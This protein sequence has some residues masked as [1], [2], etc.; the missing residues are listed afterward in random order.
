M[1]DGS[2]APS[3]AHDAAATG[4]RGDLWA[5][6]AC[7]VAAALL[8]STSGLFAKARIFDDWDPATRGL[9]LAFWRAAFAAG[10]LLPAA[11]RVRWHVLLPVMIAAF[12]AMNVLYLS[13]MARTTAA[14]AIWLQCTAPFWVLVLGPWV[15][16]EPFDRRNLLPLAFGAA[17]IGL[18][19]ACELQSGTSGASRQGLWF[20]LGAGVA[21]AVVVLSLRALR[22]EHPVWLV[23]L[24]HLAAA[25]ALAPFVLRDGPWPSPAQLGV[26]AAFGVLQMGVPYV[27]FARGLQ[28][29][30]SQEAT[31]IALCEPVLLPVWVWLA[32]GEVPAWWTLAGGALILAGL[33]LRYGRRG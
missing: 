9:Y 31:L 6:R 8:W 7:V 10:V 1:S 29:L 25:L 16:R 18:I 5:A 2:P 20:A 4:H 26:L 19:L 33:L 27:L 3:A 17:G 22:G 14:N 11:R 30:P 12:T 13:A 32:W 24:N 15:W 28:H 23:A 21:Y